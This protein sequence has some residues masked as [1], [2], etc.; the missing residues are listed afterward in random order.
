VPIR[1]RPRPLLLAARWDLPVSVDRPFACSPSLVYGP[2]LSATTPSLTSRPRS[3]SWTRPRPRVSRPRPT[4]PSL[5]WSPC[6]L[7]RSLAQ[8]C[9]QPNSLAL[10]RSTCTPVELRRDPPPFCGR[11]RASTVFVALV[12]SASSLAMRD[13]L[14]FAPAS[15]FR[16]VHTHLRSPCAA[17]APPL[18]TQGIPVSPSLLK[19]SRVSSRGEQ[20]PHALNFP[21]TALSSARLLAGASPRHR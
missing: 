16:L 15:L 5:F 3:P 6:P 1:P 20:L 21:C 17:K 11:R 12:S 2:R 13:T 7:T 4:H 10:S 14:W 19:H 9:P 18:L 8:L